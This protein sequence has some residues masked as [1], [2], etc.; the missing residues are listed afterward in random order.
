[1]FVPEWD[2]SEA[3]EDGR[4]GRYAD[5]APTLVLLQAAAA[6][7]GI[8]SFARRGEGTP[9]AAV[10]RYRAAAQLLRRANAAGR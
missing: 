10:M 7:A 5:S 3:T 4:S 8:G 2:M 1:V 6:E 9:Q